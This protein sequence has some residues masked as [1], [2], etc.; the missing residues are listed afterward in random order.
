MLK[1]QLQ[2]NQQVIK[3]QPLSPPIKVEKARNT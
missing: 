1:K 2:K 3:E